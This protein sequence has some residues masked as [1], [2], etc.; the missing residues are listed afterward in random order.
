MSTFGTT[1][2][3]SLFLESPESFSGPGKLLCVCYIDIQAQ[4]FDNF[5]NNE[6]KLS[7][8]D[9]KLTGLLA[10]NCATI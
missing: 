2:A 8:N 3:S 9:A 1:G 5:E 10:R 4:S 6:M 7:V